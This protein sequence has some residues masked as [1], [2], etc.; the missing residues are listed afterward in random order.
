MPYS[1]TRVDLTAIPSVGEVALQGLGSAA[2][3][4]LENLCHENLG[5]CAEFMPLSVLGSR[6]SLD[7]PSDEPGFA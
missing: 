1:Q 2:P 4:W 3:E 5:W 6:C 7:V